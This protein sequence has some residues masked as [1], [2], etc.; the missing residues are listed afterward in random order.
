VRR[1]G[2]LGLLVLVSTLTPIP[3]WAAG[4]FDSAPG[5]APADA[6]VVLASNIDPD[7]TL[8][9]SSL[10]RLIDGVVLFQRGLAPRL[11]LTGTHLPGR[12]SEAAARAVLAQT[13]GVP[14]SAMLV[15]ERLYTTR[16]EAERAAAVLKP[17]GVTRVL[18]VTAATHMARARALFERQG[19]AVQPAPVP[20][21][22]SSSDVPEERF[23]LLRR[24]VAE[25]AAHAYYRAAGYLGSPR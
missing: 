7:G 4:L 16:D 22:G 21:G 15:E 8:N 6:I 18:L 1:L 12:P 2:A 10:R 17:L 5:I 3:N 13:L 14:R 25:A 23:G 19:F 11:M 20:E 9:A 24:T